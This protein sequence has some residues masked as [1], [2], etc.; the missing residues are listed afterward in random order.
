M[1]CELALVDNANT[2]SKISLRACG[3]RNFSVE[4]N[5]EDELEEIP[6]FISQFHHVAL[7]FRV[8]VMG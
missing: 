4:K 7:G 5:E 2:G 6:P 3:Y 1:G 8:H